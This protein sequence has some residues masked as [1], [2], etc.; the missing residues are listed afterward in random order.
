MSDE[1]GLASR[2]SWMHDG[3]R[4]FFDALATVPDAELAGRSRLPGWS[5]AHVV[6]HVARNADALGNLLHWAR[7]GVETPM[8]PS[9]EA[10][11]ADIEA[12]VRRPPDEVRADA[13]HAA[14]RL[15]D[16][17]RTLP[18][19]A[20]GRDVRTAAGRAVPAA[21]VPWMRVREVWVHAVDLDA[22]VGFD[23]VPAELAQALLDDALGSLARRPETSALHV[24]CTDD[25]RAWQLGDGSSGDV[26]GSYTQL[27][28]WAL[29]RR[30]VY[31]ADWPALSAWL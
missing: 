14:Q 8:Y 31:V 10:R 9:R 26:R 18:E 13:A 5:R 1:S 7:T 21:E 16:A 15:A 17:V 22:G 28:S 11:A 24:R 27:L 19:A 25:G 12:G 29:G 30:D 4:L 6:S 20:W 23:V 3:T 2:L